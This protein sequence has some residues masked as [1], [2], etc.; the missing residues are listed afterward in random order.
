VILV[1]SN[2]LMYAAGAKHANKRPSLDLLIRIARGE[3]DGIIDAE[4]LQEVLHRYRALRR[5][6]DGRKLFDEARRLFPVVLPVDSEVQDL[7]RELLDEDERLTAR[8]AIHAAVVF[9][10]ELEAICSYDRDFDR[11]EDLRRVEPSELLPG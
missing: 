7:A 8:D 4:T 3:Q 1:D 10:H 2:V 11:L 9:L 5:W 6:S